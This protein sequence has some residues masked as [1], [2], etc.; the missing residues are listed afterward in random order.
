[1]RTFAKML[2]LYSALMSSAL[3][4]LPAQVKILTE[5]ERLTIADGLSND[6]VQCIFQDRRGFLWFGTVDGLNRYDGYTFKV[7]KYD[8]VDSASLS[9][10][11]VL[12]I[13]EDRAGRIWVGTANGLNR[14]DP[15]TETFTHFKHALNDPNSLSG[16]CITALC[17]D[18]D[19]NL[20]IGLRG[21]V[22][23]GGLNKLLFSDPAKQIDK[24]HTTGFSQNPPKA[25]KH[26]T[27]PAFK[28]IRYKLNQ[29]DPNNLTANWVTFI[30]EDHHGALW[31]G[32]ENGGLKKFDP[33][34]EQIVHYTHDP[35]DMN[36]ISSQSVVQGCMDQD[37]ALW[38]GFWG[39]GLDR[40]D[41][42]TGKVIHYRHD[43]KNSK[44][45]DRHWTGEVCA[46][47]SGILWIGTS[48]LSQ[49]NRETGEFTHFA[50]TSNYLANISN[51]PNCLY[52]DR[53]NNLWLATREN[54]LIKL[55][56][57][58]QK[59][60]HY[61]HNADD[62]S[63]LGGN[64]IDYL[65]E[66]K[67]GMIWIVIFD[68]GMSRFD[69]RTEQFTRFKHDP[70]DPSSLGHNFVQTIYQDRSGNL[71]FGNPGGLDRFD[72]R[73]GRIIRVLP[74][75]LNATEIY[76]ANIAR[77]CE[78]RFGT[79][80]F[81]T[82]GGGLYKL[83]PSAIDPFMAVTDATETPARASRQKLGNN[84]MRFVQ[85]LHDPED[86]TSIGGNFI[87]AIHEDQFGNFWLIANNSLNL[88]DRQT[89]RCIDVARDAE[90]GPHFDGS[91][92]YESRSGLLWAPS[93]MGLARVDFRMEK[94]ARFKIIPPDH[95]LGQGTFYPWRPHEDRFGMIWVGGQYGLLKL[96]PSAQQFT[97]HYSEKEGLAAIL[98][99]EIISDND[100]N[101]WLLTGKG[102]SIFNENAPPGK[103]FRN[104]DS[105][106]GVI[107]SPTA[108]KGL[109]KAKNGTIYW[110]GS[111][112]LHRFFPEN[113]KNNPHVPPVV[114]TEFRVF[115]EVVKLD[116]AISAKKQITLSHDQNSF[117]FSFAALD[118]TRPLSNQY[119]YR[120]E[121]FDE[122][123]IE[124][125]NPTGA[126]RRYAN[127][128]YI[129]P[130]K[131]TFRVKGSNNDGVWN[132]TGASVKIIITPPYWQTWW[133]RGLIALA[134]IGF[135]VWLYNY[136]VSKLLEIERT[137]LR[138]ARDL[139]DEVGSSLSS[140]ALMSELMQDEP[141]LAEKAK[142]ELQQIGATA[143]NVVETMGDL[144]W[145][146]NPKYD[147]LENLLLR[148]KEFA[149]EMLAPKQI[150]YSFHGPEHD[151]FQPLNMN[152]RHHLL[153][154][155]KEILHNIIKHAQ[156]KHV[157]IFITKTDGVLTLKLADDG[158]GFDPSAV[159]NGNGL[160][161]VQARAAELEGKID[162]ASQNG[163]G[164]VVTLTVK[165]P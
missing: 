109:L 117:S 119:A 92:I 37:G 72:T 43:P 26:K 101:L 121:G 79:F 36:S 61:Q 45:L 156:A 2:C 67:S 103:Q 154:I 113:L 133:F 22:E 5:Y 68:N 114:L 104:L 46:G 57:R 96:D 97:A 98:V 44:S 132:E 11:N 130:G 136:R 20:W 81:G 42:I 32:T 13:C 48:L 100:S 89:G 53:S 39:H 118:F 52:E 105:K 35:N 138:I 139:H 157:D 41:P 50:F 40:F 6:G 102:L 151:V 146:I 91:I 31:I 33:A 80:W 164:T 12:S 147:K 55:D 73:T 30:V 66:D 29:N 161:N 21:L 135:L 90:T 47:R 131:Y 9:D 107:N 165:I 129:P 162:I 14:F 86:S 159:K 153:L 69:P 87:Y 56:L 16:N 74:D 123:W 94:S 1:M 141:G 140:I 163:Q 82:Y 83:V 155:Y 17:E 112:G 88:M 28:V 24:S 145:T 160:K 70:K 19:G 77:I 142:R 76:P 10:N 84:A 54:G 25:Q 108:N 3:P 63:S 150:S 95:F 15:N 60:A 58:P 137:R 75:K 124:A 152:F 18:R 27:S 149:G 125:G 106:D 115:N 7:F 62:P 59:F 144:V 143:L 128:T 111:N 148:M 127:Y 65:Y 93:H 116:S 51:A 64:S 34:T 71:W 4:T 122:D 85:Y 78:D 158:K 49:F 8:P 126:A 99:K 38:L 23:P 120:L 110:G 134:V